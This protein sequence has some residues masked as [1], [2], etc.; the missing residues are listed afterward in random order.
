MIQNKLER[1]SRRGNM[2]NKKPQ[3][4]QKFYYS[5]VLV[6]IALMLLGLFAGNPLLHHLGPGYLTHGV[7]V[8]LLSIFLLI[9]P[10]YKSQF[11]RIIIIIVASTSFISSSFYIRIRGL[12]L[13]FY[14]LFLPF[15]FC[16]L[17]KDFFIFPYY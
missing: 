5:T 6:V 3:N 17:I 7:L 9:Y 8:F 1:F 10:S 2:N 4:N 14:A 13:Y 11:L 15:Q 12:T 16:F